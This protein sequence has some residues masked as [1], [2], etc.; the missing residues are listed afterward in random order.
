VPGTPV[1]I[2]P[3]IGAEVGVPG[4]PG[5]AGPNWLNGCGV[6]CGV[7]VV[8]AAGVVGGA[9]PGVTVVDLPGGAG[10]KV[11]G[12]VALADAGGVAGAWGG[13]A[14]ALVGADEPFDSTAT[15]VPGVG[16][17]DVGGWRRCGDS[18]S[19]DESSSIDDTLPCA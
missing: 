7:G 15:G 18:G 10:D 3:P 17:G 2:L 14:D 5:V 9:A 13:T 1:V 12:V 16:E 8:G 4:A 11:V 19:W 6:P